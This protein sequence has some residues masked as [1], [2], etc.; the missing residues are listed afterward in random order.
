ML[1]RAS[2]CRGCG[3]ELVIGASARE[4]ETGG[5]WGVGFG[6]FVYFWML[7]Q[8]WISSFE[9]IHIPFIIFI[10][11]VFG[12][13]MVIFFKSSEVRFFRTGCRY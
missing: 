12:V 6:F 10:G 13:A 8:L 1:P 9:I 4:Q 5:K 7:G 3:A 2:I 11:Y